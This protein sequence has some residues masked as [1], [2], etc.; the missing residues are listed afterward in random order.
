MAQKLGDEQLK[1]KLEKYPRP[2]NCDQV[3]TPRV[4]PEIWAKLARTVRGDDQTFSRL[5]TYLCKIVNIS[6]KSTDL[7]L[8]AKANPS[9]AVV[10][11]LVRINTDAIAIMSH[12]SYELAQRRRDNIRPHLHKDYSGLCLPDVPV[13]SHLF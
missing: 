6:L 2:A 12:M 8:Q 4:N 13:T 7:L 5:Q 9:V 3:I 1:G 11:G 10:D